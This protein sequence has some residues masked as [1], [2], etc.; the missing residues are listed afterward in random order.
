MTLDYRLLDKP[1]LETLLGILMRLEHD[2][3]DLSTNEYWAVTRL[4]QAVEAPDFIAE[5]YARKAVA[6]TPK[7]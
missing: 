4:A 7:E 5:H 6:T 3:P 1:T 2:A